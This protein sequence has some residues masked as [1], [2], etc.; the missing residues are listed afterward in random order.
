MLHLAEGFEIVYHPGEPGFR[1]W[2]RT[3]PA[4]FEQCA[5]ALTSIMV[6]L[7]TIQA[8]QVTAVEL[9]AEDQERLLFNWLVEILYLFQ[10]EG[11]VFGKF[12][13]ISHKRVD[14]AD[15]LQADF[16]GQN[17]DDDKHKL[18]ASVNADV[19][20]QVQMERT[21]DGYKAVVSLVF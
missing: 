18:K 3:L 8:Q 10:R 5:L 6:D 21:S 13:L 7:E 19:L 17:F 2:A 4:L 12:E 9:S 15:Y 1:A 20:K 16:W 11:K 14:Q